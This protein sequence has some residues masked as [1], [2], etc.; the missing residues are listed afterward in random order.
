MHACAGD[1]FVAVHQLLAL[2]ERIQEHGHGAEVERVRT[3]PHQVVEDARDLVEHRA[4][5]LRTLRHF[6]AEQVLDGAYIGV[7]VA[8]HRDVV[9]PVHVAD[10]LVVGLRFGQLL[11]AAMEQPDMRVGTDHGFA[12]HLEDQAQHAMRSGMLRA[13]I[14][15]VIADLFHHFAPASRSALDCS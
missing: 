14:H 12:V 9:E 10:R 8:H 3:D 4:D 1:R 15:R 7:L 5:P 6:D 2:A 13:E 11:G